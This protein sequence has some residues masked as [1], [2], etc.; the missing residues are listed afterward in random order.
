MDLNLNKKTALITGA[1]RGVGKTTA[2]A[3]A[4]EGITVCL[5]SRTESELIEVCDEIKDKGGRAFYYVFDLSASSNYDELKNKIIS[6]VGGID[7]L[8]NNAAHVSTPKKISYLEE[9]EWNQIIDIDLNAVFRLSKLFIDDMKNKKWGRVINIGSLSASVGVSSYPAYCAA[10]AGLEGLTKNMAVDYS[11][12][13]ITINMISPGFIETERFKKAAPQELIEK[14]IGA[15]SVKRLGK[16]E[17]ISDSI[18]FLSSE[19][20][21]YITGINLLVCGGLNLGNLW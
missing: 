7:I 21:S 13:G 9:K 17:D 12:F 14:Y 1:G 6:D 3:L 18:L 5:I 19:R 20:A 2:L 16:A 10:K 8:I 4:E 15:T 11:K